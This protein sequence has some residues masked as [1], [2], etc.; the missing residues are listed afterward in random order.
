MNFRRGRTRDE[1]EINLIPMIDVLLVILIF[2]MITTTYSRFAGLHVN[3]PEGLASAPAPSPAPRI[4]VV[5]D[6]AGQMRVNDS[7]VGVP[8]S[9]PQIRDALRQAAHGQ[10][11]PVVVVSADRDA[12][13]GQVVLVLEAAQQAGYRHLTV[14]T[15]VPAR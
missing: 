11:D 6:A 7:P 12:R 15:R 10:N 8:E 5:V 1:P 13:H 9:L 2:L 3:L 14:L 4:E